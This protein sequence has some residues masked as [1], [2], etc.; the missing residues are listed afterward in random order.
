[1]LGKACLLALLL[2]CV[3]SGAQAET[4]STTLSWEAPT[5]N[6]DG[7]PLTDLDGYRIY[8]GCTASGQYE[9]PVIDI[10]DPTV[11]S[12][13]VDGLEGTCYFVA[14]AYNVDGVESDFSGEAVSVQPVT[15]P[16]GIPVIEIQWRAQGEAMPLVNTGL[17]ARYFFDEAASGTSPTA[18]VDHSGNSFDLNDVNYSS[19]MA[20]TELGGQRGLEATA[21]GGSH[22]ARRV[23]ADGTDPLHATLDGGQHYTLEVV[24]R[25]DAFPASNGRVIVV[26]EQNT[27]NPE[28]GIAGTSTTNWN[29]GWNESLFSIG[30]LGTAKQ[31][32]HVVVDST[33]DGTAGNERIKVYQNGTLFTVGNAPVGLN[34]TLVL[35]APVDWIAFNRGNPPDARSMDGVLFYAAIYTHSFTASEVAANDDILSVDDD[36]PAGGQNIAAGQAAE[37]DTAQP[38]GFAKSKS[39]GLASDVSSAFEVTSFSNV[40][41]GTALEN[42]ASFAV[43]A[44]KVRSIG[45]VAEADSAFQITLDKANAVGPAIEADSAQA[46]ITQSGTAVSLAVSVDS[47]FP[48][49]AAKSR[50]AQLSVEVD[51]ARQV[52]ANRSLPVGLSF[53]SDVAFGIGKHRAKSIAVATESD[54]AFAVLGGQVIIVKR[55]K[56]MIKN[57]GKM[58]H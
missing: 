11:L 39:V 14:T 55:A 17:V 28:I 3:P 7:T 27:S 51:S 15:E 19:T 10:P 56:Q 46:V 47:A 18:V 49:A 32:I 12:H 42:D 40:P 20:Y 26:N 50:T 4:Y 2:L 8:H 24:V 48:I 29:F 44:S 23:L 5:E 57:V 58:F 30:N 35:G 36:A 41:V 21:T 34:D 37:T 31:V 38:V 25:G 43:G 22:Y 1:M 9:R 6:T 54:R 13:T 45:L 52:I 53:E 16:P 33:L